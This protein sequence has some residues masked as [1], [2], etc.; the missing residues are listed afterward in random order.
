MKMNGAYNKIFEELTE[1]GGLVMRGE[2]LVLPE[3]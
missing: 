3:R 1:V 2:K